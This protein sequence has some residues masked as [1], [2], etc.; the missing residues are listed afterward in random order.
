VVEDDG[1]LVGALSLAELLRAESGKQVVSL[2]DASLPTVAA[3]ADLPEVALVM[4]DYNLISIPVLDADGR[5]VG[6][7]AVDDILE[8]LLPEE[9]R[10]RAGAARG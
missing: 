1:K 6:L 7:I 9:W 8:Q 4:T 5:V 2:C 3:E 10:R